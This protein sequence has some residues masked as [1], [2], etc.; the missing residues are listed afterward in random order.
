MLKIGLEVHVSLNKVN[1]KLFCGCK[2]PDENAE[3]NSTTCEI[4]LGMPGAKPVVNKKAIEHALRLAL[5]LNF[6]INKEFFFSRKTYFYPDMT[7]NYQ[8][9]Q[10][11]VP[12]GE[13]GA[14]LL[15]SGKKIRLRRIHLEEDPGALLHYPSYVLIDYNRAGIALCE[16]VTE[17][18][19]S[20][21]EEAREFIK[22]INNVI[23]YL[24]IFDNKTGTIKAD[25]NVSIEGN[26]RV[27]VKNINGFQAI[28]KAVV[29]E[30]AR[31]ESLIKEGNGIKIRETRG[32]DADKSITIFQRSKESEEDYG[33]IFDTDLPMIELSD[34]YINELKST[35]PEL[36]HEKIE[37]YVKELKL[38]RK[39]AEILAAEHLLAD[40]FEKVAKE[41]NP[42]IAARWL[43][44][45]LMRV[46]N[47]NKKEL[48]ELELDEN[49]MIQLLSLVEKKQIT[50]NNAQKILENLVE[51]PFDVYE[52]VEINK[53]KVINEESDLAVFVKEAIKENAGAVGDYKAGKQEAFNFIIGMIMRKTKGQAKPDV[54]RKI[55]KEEIERA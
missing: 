9:T 13:N 51:K 15:D 29:Y 50:D 36:P 37:R 44:H 5:A 17:P 43:R 45:E 8:I 2:L 26:E 1:T 30:S 3:P 39:D 20:S 19:I 40:L 22:K 35:I 28:E 18:D 49:N 14:V 41:I 4:C 10:Y 24:K 31:Q 11:E 16:I 52:Y 33:Y 42:L 34:G 6:K 47:Y 46:V 23:S 32:W 38:G 27:E 55:L 21:A 54:I 12:I 25:V 7:K 53:L 48:H